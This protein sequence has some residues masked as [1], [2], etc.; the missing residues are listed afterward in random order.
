MKK[1]NFQNELEGERLILRI[2]KP[3]LETAQEILSQIDRNRDHLGKWF[4]WVQAN[5]KVED[6][7]QYLS[8]KEK[9]F[10]EQTKVAYGIYINQIYSGNISFFDLSFDK[11]SAEIGYWLDKSLTR[12]GYITESIKLIE[13]YCFVDLGLNR[14]EIKCEEN[15]IPSIEVAQKCGYTLEGKLREYRYSHY[16]QKFTDHIL[17]SKLRREFDQEILSNR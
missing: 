14:L 15:N 2:T 10:E 3:T 7:Y 6:L 12:N 8:D 5:Q 11:Q 1:V 17:F 9:H 16:L 13:K 4:P